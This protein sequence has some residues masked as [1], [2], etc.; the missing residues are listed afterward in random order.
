[1]Q[2]RIK[3][4]PISF[5]PGLFA[6]SCLLASYA[7]ADKL[8]Q[9]VYVPA[10]YFTFVPPP[11]GETFTDPV[12]ETPIT[13]ITDAASTIGA[14]DGNPLP[15]I[16]VEYSTKS[17]FNT[18]SSKILLLE[19]SYFGL[20]DGITLQRIRPLCCGDLVVGA[21][22]E[23]VWS[24]TDSNVF[25]FHPVDSNQLRKYNIAT[26]VQTVVHTFSE[27]ISISSGGEAE[28]S[29][30]GDHLVLIGDNLLTPGSREIFV[31]RI[32][33]DTKG[34]V[35]DATL[36]GGFDAVYI[37]PDNNVLIA[38]LA[39]GTGRFQGT[40]LYDE[41]MNFLR[42]VANNNGH[43]DVTRDVDG[44]EILVQTNSA[45]PTP[46]PNCQNGIVKIK[47]ATAHQTC[48]LSL[49]WSLAVHISAGDQDGWV[50]VSTYNN[51]TASSPWFVYT[52]ELLRISLDG[53]VVRRL[54]HHR[55]DTTTYE[56]QPRISVSRDGRR[57]LFNSNMMG[58]TTDVYSFSPKR[59]RGQVTSE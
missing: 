5:V 43:K 11:A 51:S 13:R 7:A 26:D 31:Y 42:Q 32:S 10:D 38:W 14:A 47:L 25:Y 27:Y 56:G 21:T 24:R 57:F 34:P 17:P 40:E 35:F 3:I 15:R 4:F 20:Y 18:D 28:I 9:N 37:T 1:M 39:T 36:T 53:S 44:S 33:T 8:D 59:R 12:F 49:D 45:D 46:I 50:Y 58:S 23:P 6:L 48:L 41:D 55:S 22:S 19:V 2:L 29:Y 54:A 16:E 30:D 52:N